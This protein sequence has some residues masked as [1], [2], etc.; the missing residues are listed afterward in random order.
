MKAYIINASGGETLLPELLS[1]D[2]Y[3]G[4]GEPCDYFDLSFPYED[5]MPAELAAAC[6]FRAEHDGETVFYGVVDEYEISLDKNGCI[7]SMSGRSL[8]AL[9]LDNE[10]EAATYDV[11][12]QDAVIR[13]HVSPYGIGRIDRQQMQP[14]SGFSVSTGDSEWSVLKRFCRYSAD[15]QPYFDRTGTLM[16]RKPSGKSISIP[17]GAQIISVRFVDR[18]YGIISEMLVK[19]RYT[20]RRYTVKNEEFL[21]RGG[22]A[23]HVLTVPRNSGADKMRYTGQYQISESRR[24]KKFVELCLPEL[25]AAFPGDVLSLD[26]A[27]PGL[28][29]KFQVVSSRCTADGSG[30][31]TTLKLEAKE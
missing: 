23:R 14:L 10:A 1:W 30:Y 29:G 31:G 19:S 7:C 16:L 21:S 2:V 26:G 15:I 6:R 25:F 11:I 5:D 22:C 28:S 4:L 3:H 12:G 20:G 18:R 24:D 13:D 8:A 9:L 17:R 27:L